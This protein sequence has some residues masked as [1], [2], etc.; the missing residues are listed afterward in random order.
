VIPVGGHGQERPGSGCAASTSHQQREGGEE[1]MAES[2]QFS[3]HEGTV[4]LYL[5]VHVSEE[6][7]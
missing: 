5:L 4:L 3:P 6:K 2:G 7:A 1:R